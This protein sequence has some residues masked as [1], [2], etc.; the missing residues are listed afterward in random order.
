MIRTL[1]FLILSLLASAAIAQNADVVD[2]GEII[3]DKVYEYKAMTPVQGYYTPTE[4]GPMRCYIT[5]DVVHVY[6]DENH[7]NR[8]MYDQ[9]YYGSSGEKVHI[10]TVEAG[11]TVYFYNSFPMNDGSFR[12]SVGK[13]EISLQVSYPSTDETPLSISTNYRATITFNIPVK[14][15]KCV[16]AVNDESVEVTPEIIDSSIVINWFATLRQWYR[17]GKISAG[18]EMSVTITGLR[19]VN[20]SSNRPDFGDGLGKLVLRYTM[21]GAPA[22]L[23]RQSGTPNSGVTDMKTY[24]LPN[25]EEG[26]VKLVFSSD[27]DPNNQPL[28]EIQYGDQDN[29]ELGLYIEHPPLKVEGNTLTIDLRGV[30]RFPDQMVPGLT[31]LSNISLSVSR[32][33][34]ADGQYVL[35]GSMSSPYSFGFSYFLRS[36]VYSIAADWV[37]VA[38]SALEAG[39]EMEIWVL[40]GKQIQFDSVDFSFVKDGIPAKVSVPYSEL[41]VENDAYEPSALLY[42]LSAPAL[43]ADPDS[44]INVTLGGLM[45]ADGLDHSS[46]ICVR[47][48]SSISGVDAVEAVDAE[49]VYY[50]LTGRRVFNPS[51]GIY[52]RKG[53]KIIK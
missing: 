12:F 10:Y 14:C 17:E 11:K 3:P 37:P 21:A 23:I 8:I 40:N 52:I 38:G 25:G 47:Y 50:D 6:D 32:I 53:K 13:E 42:Y 18:D 51:K 5:G 43:D 34:S 44:E 31:P 46:D 36:V 24:Y 30:T 48:K 26:L 22:E 1:S 4:S 29:I 33:K 7:E 2:W 45:C 19:D 9:Y 20:D 35:T 16:L 41:K 27:L 49:A 28:A 15:T 39:K